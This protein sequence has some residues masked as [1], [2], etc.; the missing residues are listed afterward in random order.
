[1][2]KLVQDGQGDFDTKASNFCLK[3]P[4]HALSQRC[5]GN[6]GSLNGDTDKYCK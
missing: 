6:A 4:R 3:R 2:A 1:M 5:I